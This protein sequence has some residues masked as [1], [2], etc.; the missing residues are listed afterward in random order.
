MKID[1]N[2]IHLWIRNCTATNSTLSKVQQYIHIGSSIIISLYKRNSM[3]HDS[4]DGGYS[5]VPNKH[6]GYAY[7]FI[8]KCLAQTRFFLYPFLTLANVKPILCLKTY[9]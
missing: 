6:N 3:E 4:S 5:S 8:E 1:V 9:V 7:N 2:T